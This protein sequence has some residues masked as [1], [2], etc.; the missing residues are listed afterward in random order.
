MKKHGFWNNYWTI[1]KEDGTIVMELRVGSAWREQASLRIEHGD[2]LHSDLPYLAILLWYSYRIGSQ[3]SAAA[4][5]MAAG[6]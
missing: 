1:S 2:R 5:S 6:A 4:A 3:E